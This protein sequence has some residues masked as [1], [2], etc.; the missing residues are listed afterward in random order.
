MQGEDG[1][2]ESW[3]AAALARRVPSLRMLIARNE[4][5]KKVVLKEG[6]TP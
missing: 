2:G 6:G 4:P 3:L 5:Y 1:W